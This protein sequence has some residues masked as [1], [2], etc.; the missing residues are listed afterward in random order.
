MSVHDLRLDGLQEQREDSLGFLK[1]RP[2]AGCG[3]CFST[4]THLLGTTVLHLPWLSSISSF[5]P[6][7]VTGHLCGPGPLGL[8]FH[9]VK[10]NSGL[11]VGWLGGP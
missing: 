4:Q 2:W 8:G 11:L 9:F 6:C 7:S 10:G 1:S 5:H 3:Y